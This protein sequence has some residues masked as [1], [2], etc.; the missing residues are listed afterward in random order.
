[1]T[2]GFISAPFEGQIAMF[3]CTV[4]KDEYGS[5]E[6]L[7]HVLV[8]LAKKFVF[9]LEEGEETQFK[10]WQIRMSLFGKTRFGAFSRDI[11]PKIPGR[12]SVTSTPALEGNQ[13][14]YVMKDQTRLEG[15]WSDKDK[16]R[17]PPEMTPQLADFIKLANEDKLYP[18][19]KKCIQFAKARDDRRI[20]FVYD[21]NYNSGKS[22]LCEYMEYLRIGEEIPPYPCF[23]D[24]IQFVMCQ[25]KATC[26]M[27]DMP[28]AQKKQNM[29]QMYTGLEM[30]KN[31]FCYDKR[32]NGK[33]QRIA[34]PAIIVFTN[35]PPVMG[36]IAPDRIQTWLVGKNKDISPYYFNPADKT[37]STTKIQDTDPAWSS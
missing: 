22:I 4:A 15:P 6:E 17:D 14:N 13:F 11:M 34:R 35:T 10:H 12:W 32:Y 30:L 9:Q 3:D 37:W 27:F 8:K 7:F 28:A 1:M 19:Q 29:S 24:I 21:P 23:E 36:L 33:K 25:P 20:M 5:Y 16:V 26:Y 31:G 2:Q 18:W